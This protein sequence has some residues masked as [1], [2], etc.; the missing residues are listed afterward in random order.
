LRAALA[1]IPFQILGDYSEENQKDLLSLPRNKTK[2]GDSEELVQ[3]QKVTLQ[4][5][6]DLIRGNNLSDFTARQHVPAMNAA[7]E[8]T[9]VSDGV[10]ASLNDITAR[11]NALE[12]AIGI[13]SLQVRATKEVPD[14]SVLE[15][16]CVA[17]RQVEGIGSGGERNRL[18]DGFGQGLPAIDLPHADLT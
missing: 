14:R 4:A 18:S 1:D 3:S 17:S 10:A 15:L 2:N 12:R 5:D 11:L 8:A 13:V 9:F 16:G 7:H 6:T